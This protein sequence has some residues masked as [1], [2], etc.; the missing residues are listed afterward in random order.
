VRPAP[1]VVLDPVDD[2]L[3]ALGHHRLARTATARELLDVLDSFLTK[4]AT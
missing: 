1:E 4:L 2:Y 3:L